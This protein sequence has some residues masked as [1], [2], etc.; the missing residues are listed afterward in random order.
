MEEIK[1]FIENFDGETYDFCFEIM[2]RYGDNLEVF[3]YVCKNYLGHPK[4]GTLPVGH[5]FSKAEIEEYTSIYG[6][7]VDGLLNSNIKKCNLGLIEQKDFYRSLWDALCTNFASQKE[8]AFAFYYIII[9]ATIPYQY[10]GKPISMS[11]ERFKE[12]IEKNKTTIDKIKYIAKSGYTQRTEEASLLLN[13]LEE[14]E[15]FESKVVVLVQGM[16]LLNKPSA[17]KHLDLDTLIKQIDK[18]IEELESK[19]DQD[20]TT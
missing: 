4:N 11:N 6:N 20:T 2:Q 5:H 3:E 12:I 19:E 8:K 18:K 1:N 14:I 15:D 7:T 17:T 16:M 10:L 9:D 13:C